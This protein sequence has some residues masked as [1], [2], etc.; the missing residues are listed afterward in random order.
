MA[1]GAGVVS[2]GSSPLAAQSIEPR[3][4]SN[5]P[6]GASFLIA[7]IAATDG[8]LSIDPAL[9]LT[10]PELRTWSS[11]LGYARFLDLWGKSAKVDVIVP[12]TF[13]SG[14]ALFDGESGRA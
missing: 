2:G 4:Y 9:P 8:G 1:L 3:N 7:G 13:L 5:A 12:Y 14:H 10:D 6:I 11:V